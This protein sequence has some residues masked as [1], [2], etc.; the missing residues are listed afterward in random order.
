[1]RFS[2]SS[3]SDNEAETLINNQTINEAALQIQMPVGSQT[4]LNVHE[5]DDTIDLTIFEAAR[6]GCLEKIITQIEYLKR[7][8]DIKRLLEQRNQ[9]EE[10]P[11]H[12]AAK[13][14]QENII[15]YLVNHNV[16][17]D[18]PDQQKNTPLHTA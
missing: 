16:W 15:R 18:V 10:T 12:V 13:Y 8:D 3:D 17:I 5:L 4:D 2:D 1:R 7:E 11:L 14:N 9:C 6:E